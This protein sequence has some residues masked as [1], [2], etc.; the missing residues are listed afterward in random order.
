[1]N[2]ASERARSIE[3][4]LN[5]AARMRMRAGQAGIDVG[6]AL[7]RSGVGVLMGYLGASFALDALEA[8]KNEILAGDTAAGCAAH[9]QVA[10]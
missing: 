2:N 9:R 3:S 5:H 10:G 1:M 6:T 4:S 8:A 7:I